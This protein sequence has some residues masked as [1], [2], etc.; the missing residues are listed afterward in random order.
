MEEVRKSLDTA[1]LLESYRE[2]LQQVDSLPLRVTGNSM[3][4]F[5]VHGR[6][7]VTLSR[8]SRPLKTGDVVLYQRSGGAYVLHRIARCQNGVYTMVGDAQTFLE[9]G[10][11]A[12]QM[13]AVVSAVCRK[14]KT[15]GPHDFWWVFFEK[16]WIRLLP[17]RPT[18]LRLYGTF[19][20][21]L[22]RL[23]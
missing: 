4:P 23:L 18:L 9:P 12:S 8:I 10:I 15:L 17:L 20:K 1:Q 22:G 21:R 7:T 6:D 16:I 13:I 5:L 3:A 2:L 11:S 19:R 14:G